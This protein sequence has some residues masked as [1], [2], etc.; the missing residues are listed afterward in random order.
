MCVALQCVAMCCIVFCSCKWATCP[1]TSGSFSER[2]LQHTP[3]ATHNNTQQHTA[4][5][6]N[7]ICGKRPANRPSATHCNTLQQTAAHCNTVCGKRPARSAICNTLQHTATPFAE[8]SAI[9]NI[10]QKK[11]CKGKPSVPHCSTLQHTAAHCSTL[12]RTAAHYSSLQHTA[13]H[14]STLQLTAAHCS[15]QKKNCNI[16]FRNRPAR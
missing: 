10:R 16:I 7:T 2:D 14:C 1:V 12:Q 6:C 9:S 5:H 15:T 4:A 11:T 13:A 3:S 8:R